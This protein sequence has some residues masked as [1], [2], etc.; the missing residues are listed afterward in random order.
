MISVLYVDDEPDL[1][2][3]GKLYLERFGD[4]S[5]FV[6][7]SASAALALLKKEP[8]DAVISDYQMPEMDGL[9]FLKQ[10]RIIHGQIPFILFTGRGREEV[11][12][13]AL[14]LGVDFYLQKGGDPQPQFAELAHKVRQAVQRRMGDLALEESERRYRDVVETQTEF[15]SRFKPDG[16]HVF[17]NEVYC[18]HFGKRRDEVVG[19]RFVP[20]IPEEDRERVRRHF[21]SFSPENPVADIEH[22]VLM[23]D[24]STRWH[25]WNDH[26]IFNDTGGI[27]EFQSLGKDITDRKRAEEAIKQSENLYRTLFNTTG[28][29]TII[30]GPDTTILLA[31]SGWEKLTGVPRSEQETKLSWTVFFE[32]DDAERMT[33]YHYARREDPSLAPTAYESRLIDTQKRVHHCMVYIHLIPG[34][35]NSVASLVDITERRRAEEALRLANK[36]LSLLSGITRHDINNQLQALNGFVGLLQRNISDPSFEDYFSRIMKASNQITAIIAFTREYEKIGA[37]TPVWQNLGTV[38]N[39]AERG[40]I[41]GQI[42]LISDLPARTEVFADPMLAKVFFNLLDNSLRHGQGVTE[43][44]VSSRRSG[45]DLV[46]VW[47]DDGVGIAPD[48]KER[49][50]ERGYGKHTGLGMFL[51]REILSL[52][53]IR[54][55]ETGVPGR[56]ARFEMVVPEG[57]WRVAVSAKRDG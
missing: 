9:E 35:N 8:F 43:I 5:V 19:H 42:D 45:E 14:N 48:E 30:S 55:T 11:V 21:A 32:K 1:L 24:G 16:T 39:S 28:S 47:E 26:A 6:I 36:K 15:I 53:G 29:A 17:A 34:T 27:I 25:W 31:N 54:I 50:F 12:I 41:P 20:S 44:R 37:G 2:D 10:V 33:K 13:R 22:G 57:T 51:A 7:D 23:P 3:I 38:L 49:I 46:V 56:G 40:I 4:I 18:R 52:T